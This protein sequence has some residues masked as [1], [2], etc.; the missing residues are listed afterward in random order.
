MNKT[1]GQQEK[2]EQLRNYFRERKKAVVAYSGGVDSTFLLKVAHEVLKDQVLAVTANSS[3]LPGRE[4][5]EAR[6]FC[7]KEGIRQVIFDADR[8]QR[9]SFL[10]NPPNRCYL[11]KK[12]LFGRIREIADEY[13]IECVAEGSNM[14]D[15]EE[16]RPGIQAVEELYIQSPLRECGLYKEE[17]R[18]LSRE[19][20][21]DTWQKP[22]FACL[23]SRFVCGEPIT[24]EK[25]SMVERAEQILFGMGFHQFRVR[26]HGMMARIEVLPEEM[27]M[28]MEHKNRGHVAEEFS[29]IGFSHTAVDLGGYRTGSMNKI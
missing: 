17:I 14:D 3:A 20:G 2:L 19:M 16:Y 29:R 12:Q 28:L 9:E 24:P 21:L 22:S 4:L 8:L 1:Q 6:A 15:L 13:G 5:E 27:D 10:Q 25:L 26:M 23:A 11:C 18:A 7:E